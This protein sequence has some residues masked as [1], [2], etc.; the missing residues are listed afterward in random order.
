MKKVLITGAE[1]LLGSQITSTFRDSGLLEV[2]SIGRSIV[3]LTQRD[4]VFQFFHTAKPDYIIN[5]AGYTNV[6]KAESSQEDAFSSN[7]RLVSNLTDYCKES[8]S[9]LYHFSSDYVF[10]GEHASPINVDSPRLP[11]NY[12]GFTKMVAEDT[13]LNAIPGKSVVIRTSWLYGRFGKS[14]VSQM[15]DKVNRN[16]FAKVVTDQ[17]GS[18]TNTLDLSERVLGL[19]MNDTDCGL[20]H[21]VG[22]S[23]TTWFEV[24][25]FIFT[26]YGI[27]EKLK[28]ITSSELELV[29][30]RPK[31]SYLLNSSLNQYG[32]KRM[33]NWKDSLTA[34]LES[35]VIDCEF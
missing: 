9:V 17:I 29:A 3:D 4:A 14:F 16:E 32:V 20:L 5:C 13:I 28:P 1:G 2:V 26:Y 27:R 35:G 34:F 18:P 31:Y 24:A 10:G 7:V 25:E 8:D 11:M 33:A 19:I 22:E 30:N 21:I 23:E 6:E 15:I 12:Y